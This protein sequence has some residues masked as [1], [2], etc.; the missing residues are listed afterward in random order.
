MSHLRLPPRAV[1]EAP[2]TLPRVAAMLVVIAVGVLGF[3]STGSAVSTTLVINE[4]DYDQPSGDTAEFFEL[5]NV[6]GGPINLDPY[7]GGAD[8]CRGARWSCRL[9]GV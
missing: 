1:V 7:R 2:A 4:V 8:Q 3:A 5:K 9:S 6:S